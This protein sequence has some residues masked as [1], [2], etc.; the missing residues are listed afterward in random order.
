MGQCCAPERYNSFELKAQKVFS[1]G[2][3]FLLTYVY[4]R[5]RSAWNTLTDSSEYANQFIWQDSNQ[6]RHRF[7]AA[8]TYQLPFGKGRTYLSGINRLGDALVGGWQLT[9]C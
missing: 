1:K 9:G 2:Y 8:G 3:N 6:P 5:E 7:N 4:I